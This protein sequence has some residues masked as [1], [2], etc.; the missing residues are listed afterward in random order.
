MK[1][2]VMLALVMA[3]VIFG[4]VY[5][6]AASLNVLGGTIQ[7]GTDD[8]LKCTEAVR[9]SGWGLETDDSSVYNVKLTGVPASCN[10]AQMWVRVHLAGGSTIAPA[11]VTLSGSEATVYTFA[12][13]TPRP[14]A[15]SIEGLTVLIEGPG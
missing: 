14:S 4:A 5:A 11:A 7:A 6:S 10:T 12:L 3:M 2:R 8:Y 13:G 9:V 15:A 1:K